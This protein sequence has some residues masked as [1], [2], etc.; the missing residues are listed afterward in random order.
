[1]KMHSLKSSMVAGYGYDEAEKRLV[2]RFMR[3][4]KT[5]HYHGVPKDV[6]EGLATAESPGSYLAARIRG[7][8]DHTRPGEKKK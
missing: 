7:K 5:Y 4:G 1:V 6:A 8:Y 2:V 3:G